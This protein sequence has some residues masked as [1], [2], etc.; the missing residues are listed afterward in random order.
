MYHTIRTMLR[1]NKVIY[2]VCHLLKKLKA[3]HTHA[4][5]ERHKAS[6]VHASQPMI[7][8]VRPGL[9]WV[10]PIIMN[11]DLKNFHKVF[12]FTG[13]ENWQ[14]INK[15]MIQSQKKINHSFVDLQ[16]CHTEKKNALI[17]TTNK[18]PL[19]KAKCVLIAQKN[20]WYANQIEAYCH[21]KHINYFWCERFFDDRIILDSIGLPYTNE[22]ELNMR[23][24]TK[25]SSEPIQYPVNDRQTQ[26]P[27]TDIK[28]FKK[29]YHLDETHKIIVTFG[30]TP[31]DMSLYEY[32]GLNYE[33]W[34]ETLFKENPEVV[35]LFKHHP[36]SP[37]QMV[38][39]FSNVYE[40]NEN[41]KFLFQHFNCFAAY[42][43]TTILEC[44][45]ANRPIVTGGNHY[46]SST[47]LTLK[48]T[49]PNELKN[50]Y[51][52]LSTFMLD[53]EERRHALAV[54]CNDYTYSLKSKRFALKITNENIDA[55]Q[56]TH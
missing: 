20:N 15:Q 24:Q 34:L 11:A 27:S 12:L 37:T 22:N 23:L 8:F 30:Q 42:C 19:H 6:L 28:T 3:Q 33:S 40:I 5:N 39:R 29:R 14:A 18:I 53:P 52:R 16:V 41:I 48:A 49:Q 1:N 35:F 10:K 38:R 47:G 45:I 13:G 25:Q 7:V 51:S 36:E 56:T 31:Y 32:D 9:D 17:K 2:A 44:C 55:T 46:L 50:I 21:T 54:I 26:P 4:Q 43:S